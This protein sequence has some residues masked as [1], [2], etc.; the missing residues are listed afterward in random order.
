MTPLSWSLHAEST[1]P[2]P[3][4]PH[5]LVV[6]AGM[7]GLVAAR[8]LQASGFRVTVLEARDRIGGRLHTSYALG[9]PVDLGATWIHGADENPLT[10]WFE[11]SGIRTIH[12]PQGER[13]F[14]DHGAM[15][16]F[17]QV[18]RKGW[19]GLAHAGVAASRASLRQRRTG[20][21]VSIA[22]AMQPIIDD[23]RLPLFDRCLLAWIVSTTE[24]VQGAPAE[25]IP[26]QDWY[27][28]EAMGINTV[29]EGGYRSLLETLETG[30]EIRCNSPVGKIVWGGT[31]VQ[32][33]IL[34]GSTDA[35]HSETLTADAVLITVPLGI[36]KDNRIV[37]DPP[38]P[39]PKQAAIQR[40]G[41]GEGAVLNKVVL[42]FD[43]RFWPD[44]NERMIVLP[45]HPQER[46]RYTNWINLMPVTDALVLVGFSSGKQALWQ[47]SVA[48]DEEIVQAALTTLGRLSSTRLPQPT[49]AIVTRWQ[50]DPW[51][52]GSYSYSSLG[53]DDA[54]RRDY[55]RPV[56]ER[57]YFAGEGTQVHD[58]G[59]VQAAMQSGAEAAAQIYR[60]FLRREPT[61]ANLPWT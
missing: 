38:L 20:E 51:S 56:G 44:R 52:L 50:S 45:A 24:G 26:L 43:Q 40:I 15:Q 27:P 9:V 59:T 33:E 3:Q 60:T 22:D 12:A 10:R 34:P 37:F 2:R 11:R 42:R 6:G 29:P 54:D 1:P 25:H 4:P 14:Y 55:A 16:R 58:Y 8:L 53:S 36:L 18:V 31:G 7:A 49:G 47:D 32:A 17:S 28:R 13:G 39:A 61:L 30:L 41:Y 46:G 48:S 5:I 23:T 57:L 35:H 21:P 19:R